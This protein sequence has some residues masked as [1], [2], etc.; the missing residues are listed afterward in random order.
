[1]A[2][3]DFGNPAFDE[4]DYDDDTEIIYVTEENE[5]QFKI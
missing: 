4:N 2:G 5:N 3:F 1:M